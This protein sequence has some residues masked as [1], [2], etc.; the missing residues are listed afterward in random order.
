[1]TIKQIFSR[2]ALATGVLA[3]GFLAAVIAPHSALAQVKGLPDFTELFE[4]VGP[5]VVNIRSEEHT[6]ELQ[7]P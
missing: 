5:S 1:M 6:S 4:Q 2:R 3:F 7:S